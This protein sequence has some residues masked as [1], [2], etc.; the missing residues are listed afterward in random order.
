ME[1]VAR[2]GPPWARGDWRLAGRRRGECAGAGYLAATAA[3]RGAPGALE[4]AAAC[5][6]LLRS[7]RAPAAV[8]GYAQHS[9]ATARVAGTGQLV[10]TRRRITSRPRYCTVPRAHRAPLPRSGTRDGARSHGTS[11]QQSARSA[12]HTLRYSYLAQAPACTCIRA[13]ARAQPRVASHRASNRLPAQRRCPTP[14]VELLALPR[15]PI[16][17]APVAASL[18]V[19][20]TRPALRYLYQR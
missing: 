16:G 18:P 7:S 12:S 8:G 3:A 14:V 9:A 13:A 1:G 5:M 11:S 20:G 2:P 15:G 4:V 10:P 19:L 6:Y 17:R